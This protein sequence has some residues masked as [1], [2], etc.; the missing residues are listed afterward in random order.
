M[1]VVGELR[2]Y[3]KENKLKQTVI[4][5]KCGWSKQKTSVI[6]RGKQRM[7]AEDLAAIC[8]ALGVPYD[9]FYRKKA[10]PRNAGPAGAGG[11]GKEM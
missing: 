4:S 6:I 11:H 3:M 8:D 1:S 7:T 10:K 9:Y 5:E 2:E